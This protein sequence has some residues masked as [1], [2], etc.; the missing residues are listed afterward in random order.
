MRWTELTLTPAASAIA[1]PVQ[2]VVSPGGASI[3]ERNDALGDRGI[4]FGNA[5][6]SRLVAQKAF[7]AL[8]REA[9]LPAPNASLGLAGL[10]HD[11]DSCRRPSAV[12][13]TIRA[14]QTCF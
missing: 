10:A 12:S 8:D 7:E 5:R 6:G 2:C 9:L 11:R 1:A 14:R 4:E 13:S 3:V